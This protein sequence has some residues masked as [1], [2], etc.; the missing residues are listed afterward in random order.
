MRAASHISG[1]T[2]SGAAHVAF[3]AWV[4]FDGFLWPS[5][6]PVAV[7][8]V[9]VISSAEFD[10]LVEAAQPPDIAPAPTGL[11]PPAPVPQAPDLGDGADAPLADGA[12]PEA[13]VPAPLE[14]VPQAPDRPAP[15]ARIPDLAPDL[16]EPDPQPP[17][18][19]ARPRPAERVAPLPVPPAPPDSTPDEVLREEVTR[20]P[21]APPRP[22]PVEEQD[23]TAPEEAGTELAT[24]ANQ[25]D[26][27][28]VPLGRSLRPIPRPAAARPEPAPDPAPTPAPDPAPEPSPA[29][30][31][32]AAVAAALADALG[33]PAAPAGPPLTQGEK[34]ALRV[35]V[36]RCWNVGSL[37]TDALATTV[38]VAVDM[39][40]NARPVAGSI[41]MLSSSGGTDAAARQA[42]EAARRAIIRCGS[43]GF[44]LP[45]EKYDS[46]QSIEM[47]FNP[48]RMRIK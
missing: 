41:R 15:V 38:V 43:S 3:V 34:D 2:L 33:S 40:P 5:E 31:T 39:E 35:S 44:D 36:S 24:E 23:A 1:T 26:P 45:R 21:E 48:E 14:P 4:V 32:D 27:D 20:A 9:S 28:P 13:P 46:W 18:P 17:V 47:T 19:V 11:T 42:F 29:P 8:P 22:V 12:P 37:S 25:P 16:P 6:P 30:G 10:A 7:Q